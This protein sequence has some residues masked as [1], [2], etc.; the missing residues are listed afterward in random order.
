MPLQE[1]L[2]RSDL[3]GLGVILPKRRLALAADDRA[4]E[5]DRR[6]DTGEVDVAATNREYFADAG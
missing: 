3:A 6:S 1:P 5:P 4:G 2:D